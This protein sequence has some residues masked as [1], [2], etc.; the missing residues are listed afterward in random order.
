[1]GSST[2]EANRAGAW[3][4]DSTAGRTGLALADL[5]NDFRITTINLAATPLP[6]TLVAF[7]GNLNG[8]VANLYWKTSSELN[9]DYFEI[10]RSSDGFEFLGIAKVKGKGT[11]NA[12]T[13]YF[14]EDGSVTNGK[15]YY[16]LK[17]FDFDGES[18]YSKVIVLDF[19]GS[20]PIDINL[21]PNPTSSENIN[22]EII[23]STEGS[24]SIKIF[25]LTGRVLYS[26]NAEIKA[27]SVYQPIKSE[28]LKPGVYA[29]E[30]IQGLQRVVKRLV[31]NK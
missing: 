13:E 27:K 11:T 2:I 30:V 4:K 16:R 23:N 12:T 14:S 25:D 24:A 15:N 8:S 20:A 21:Y 31:I 28:S 18:T 26:A 10:Q 19:D 9:N 22:L 5:T 6:V 7:T 1:M 17:Q 29:V 3:R